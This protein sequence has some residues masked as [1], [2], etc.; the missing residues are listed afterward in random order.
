MMQGGLL[1]SLVSVSVLIISVVLHEL[2]H[3]YTALALGDRTA[4]LAGRLSINPIRHMDWLGSVILPV[5]LS[6]IGSPVVFGWAKPVPV[7]MRYISHRYGNVL[8]SLA[9]PASNLALA[10]IFALV[11]RFIG[12]L[13]S[14]FFAVVLLQTVLVNIALFCFNLIPIPPFDGYHVVSGLLPY[15][16]SAKYAILE[17]YQLPLLLVVIFLADTIVSA[18]ASA[19]FK[20]LIGS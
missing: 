16:L 9:G 7:N 3:G 1:I 14:G 13:D 12:V 20:I 8:V 2:A 19:L 15:R 11:F 10:I 5:G 18:P 6:L 17:R 4:L